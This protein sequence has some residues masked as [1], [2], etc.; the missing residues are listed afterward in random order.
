M[1]RKSETM[2]FET[3]EGPCEITVTQLDGNR[4]GALG[5]RLVHLVGPSIVSLVGAMEGNETSKAVDAAQ[6][7]IAKLTPD[8]FDRIKTEVLRGAQAKYNGE[9]TD[10]DT[11][12]IG[13][14]FAGHPGSL[15]KLIGFALKVNFQNFFSDLGMSAERIQGA[16]R[17]AMTLKTAP[18]SKTQ[19]ASS[20]PSGG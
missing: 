10:V 18:G 8:E 12:F 5:V 3:S 6:A 19:A 1:A 9:F 11:K 15:Y 17:N 13:E 7:L 14:A 4:G 2:E 16:V 20:G